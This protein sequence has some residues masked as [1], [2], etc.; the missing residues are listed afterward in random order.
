MARPNVFAMKP[1]DGFLMGGKLIFSARPTQ[2]SSPENNPTHSSMPKTIDNPA[3]RSPESKSA[4]FRARRPNA[5]SD[6]QPNGSATPVAGTVP[7]ERPRSA[8]PLPK[9]NKGRFFVGSIFLTALSFGGYLFWSTFCQYQSYGVIQGRIITVSAP[10]NGVVVNWQIKEGELVTQGQPLAEIANL[11]MRHSLEALID[12][13][14]LT[15]AQ[16][17]AESAKL[18]FE[19]QNLETESRLAAADYLQLAGELDAERARYADLKKQLSRAKR[20]M[21]SKHFSQQKYDELNFE[22]IGQQRKI[23]KMTD[24][25][26]ALELRSKLTLRDHTVDRQLQI[27]PLLTKIETTQ[28]EIDRIREKIGQGRLL[29]PV[30][31]RVVKRLC[32]T[33]ESTILHEPIAEILED[34]STEAILYVPQKFADRY[35]V[36]DLV[37]I[38]LPPYQQNLQCEI[39]R[40]QDQLQSPP[41]QLKRYYAAD[42][43]LLP[44]HL[45]PLPEYEQFM[46]FRINGTIKMPVAWEQGVWDFMAGI[47]DRT[48]ELFSPEQQVNR[49]G[50]A[51]PANS[52]KSIKKVDD[53]L[54]PVDEAVHAT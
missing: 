44:V 31:G 36:G 9:R 10:W 21:E 51:L 7:I 42:E 33:G 15:Q 25:V 14:K 38:E 47:R 17:E 16:L 32:L 41:R 6:R 39:T 46:S 48:S 40:L 35:V 29:S 30:T 24:A 49:Q 22:Y 8:P 5:P 45:K 11:E 27:Q 54:V 52:A 4:G 1:I 34:N 18:K 20:L 53:R 50:Q 12:D 37:E 13:L 28:S 3:S 26:A 2:V 23:G 19:Q 43:V